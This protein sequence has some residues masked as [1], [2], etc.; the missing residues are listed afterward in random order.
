M[1]S[2]LVIDDE[3]QMRSMLRLVL[4]RAGH[5]VHD[6]PNGKAGAVVFRQNKFDLTI[7]D[8]LM[9]EREGIET[10]SELKQ[11]APHTKIIAISGGG[12]TKNFD[13]LKVARK[14]GAD[15][16]LAKPFRPQELVDMIDDLLGT[17]GDR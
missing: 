11:I 5:S 10:I 4:E 8:I 1:A 17:T 7:T 15:R 9:P 6:A 16:T 12:R 2:I 3:P 13:F 14:M